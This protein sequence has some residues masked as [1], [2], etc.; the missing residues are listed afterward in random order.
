MDIKEILAFIIIVLILIAIAALGVI[1]YG[2]C[3]SYIACQKTQGV[4][5]AFKEST[6]P[7]EKIIDMLHSDQN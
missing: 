2:Y 4:I 1:G 6:L 7:P 5:R 3:V